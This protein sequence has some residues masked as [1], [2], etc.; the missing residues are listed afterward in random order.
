MVHTRIRITP[1][2]VVF[3]SKYGFHPKNHGHTTFQDQ[4]KPN[5]PVLRESANPL[6]PVPASCRG[7]RRGMIGINDSPLS[8]PNAQKVDSQDRSRDRSRDRS[9]DSP[10][11]SPGTGPQN[12]SWNLSW[13]QDQCPG[14]VLGLVPPGPGPVPGRIESWCDRWYFKLLWRPQKAPRTGTQDTG[15]H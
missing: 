1:W 10:G 6:P 4:E 5:L 13:S 12:R 14:P 2:H 9:W 8:T 15:R 7:D 3:L 11:T